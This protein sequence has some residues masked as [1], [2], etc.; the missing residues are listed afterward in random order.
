[1]RK[2]FKGSKLINKRIKPLKIDD[3]RLCY[4]RDGKLFAFENKTVLFE[5]DVIVAFTTARKSAKIK[6]WIYGL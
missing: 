1:M 4:I 5:E 6:Q 2:I 3:T